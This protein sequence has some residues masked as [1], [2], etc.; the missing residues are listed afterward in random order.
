G[1][2]DPYVKVKLGINDVVKT[3]Y[4]KRTLSPRFDES[5]DLMVYERS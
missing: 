4:K 2:S 5:F 3:D 1:K